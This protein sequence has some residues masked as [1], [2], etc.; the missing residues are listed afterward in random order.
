MALSNNGPEVLVPMTKELAEF[1][2][3]NCQKNVEF[4]AAGCL[5][6]K[7]DNDGQLKLADL[8]RKFQELQGRVEEAVANGP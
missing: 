2:I 1:V 8:A 4:A 7:I 3:D 5:S 6:G